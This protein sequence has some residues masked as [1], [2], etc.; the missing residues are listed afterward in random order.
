MED[1]LTVQL[2]QAA[3]GFHLYVTLAIFVQ[4]HWLVELSCASP[5][6]SYEM[7]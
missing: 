1:P 4:L 3:A 5:A 6:P 7:A 2:N